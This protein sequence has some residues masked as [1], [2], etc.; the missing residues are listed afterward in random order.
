MSEINENDDVRNTW[1]T[2]N[3]KISE[4]LEK[5]FNNHVSN[6]KYMQKKLFPSLYLLVL[7]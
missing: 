2:I 4:K 3:R 5:Y 1:K 7:S 6:I